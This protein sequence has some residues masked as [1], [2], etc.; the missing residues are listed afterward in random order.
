[1]KT[2]AQ[3]LQIKKFPFII[4]DSN[5]NVIYFEY[6]DRYWFKYAYDSN[7]NEIYWE[8]SDGLWDKREYDSNRK[9]IYR[10]NSNGTIHD[11]RPKTDIQKAIDLLTKEGLLVDGKILK[12]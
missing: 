8:N 4:K 5:D 7:G 9:L 2:I 1:M 11:Y 6:S 12:Q 3:Q 10:E